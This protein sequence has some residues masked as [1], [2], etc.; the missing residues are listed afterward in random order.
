MVI[1]ASLL[2]PPSLR[3]AALLLGD[4]GVTIRA[5]SEASGVRCPVCGEP[6]ERV[7]RR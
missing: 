6:A 2:I 5:I 4:D 7:H 3:V 1:A